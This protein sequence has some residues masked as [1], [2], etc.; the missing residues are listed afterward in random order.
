MGWDIEIKDTFSDVCLPNMTS[1]TEKQQEQM[2]REV[3][4]GTYTLKGE[5]QSIDMLA[6]NSKRSNDERWE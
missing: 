2:N 3:T 1:A 4:Q 6:S 5:T